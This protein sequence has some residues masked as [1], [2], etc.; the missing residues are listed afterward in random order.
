MSKDNRRREKH[1]EW[2]VCL[3]CSY[4]YLLDAHVPEHQ[5]KGCMICGSKAFERENE[6]DD[7]DRYV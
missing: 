5:Q 3:N 4:E 1:D 6:S 2:V 7:R